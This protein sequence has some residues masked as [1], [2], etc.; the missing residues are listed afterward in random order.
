MN[1]LDEMQSAAG[2]QPINEAHVPSEVVGRV[3]PPG[4]L[5][6]CGCCGKTTRDRYGEQGGW[7]ES[8]MLNSFLERAIKQ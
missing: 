8:C 4:W 7:D 2:P 1:A 3:A 5:W 6:R